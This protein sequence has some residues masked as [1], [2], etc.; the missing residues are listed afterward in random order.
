[1]FNRITFLITCI[2]IRL[3]APAQVMVIGHCSLNNVPI[4][5]VGIQV[6]ESGKVQSL[7]STA[8]SSLFRTRLNFGKNYIL[9]FTHPDCITQF[10]EVNA[11]SV[12]A[13]KQEMLM[14]YEVDLPFF[15]KADA[16]IDSTVFK[17]A[18]H[19][20]VWNGN[21]QMVDDSVYNTAFLKSV[22]KKEE[23]TVK[24]EN[25]TVKETPVQISGYFAYNGSGKL[26]PAYKEVRLLDKDNRVFRQVRTNRYGQF[27]FPPVG[28]ND[29]AWIELVFPPTEKNPN[30]AITLYSNEKKALDTK[31]LD[32]P[33]LRF[34]VT[35]GVFDNSFTQMI[36][37]KLIVSDPNQK[38]FFANTTVYL[39]NNRNT[40]LKK[41]KTNSFGAFVFENIKPGNDYL[42]GVDEDQL[43]SGQ[44]LDLINK[45]D[46][47]GKTLDSL[48]GKR[49]SAKFSAND[50][51][52][53]NDIT[54]SEEDMKM[55]ISATLYGDN[56]NNPLGKLKI[57]LLND[58]YEPI[59]SA[60]TDNFGTFKFKYLPFL[61]RFFLSA[62]NGEHNLDVFTNVLVYSS[63]ENLI[64][65]ITVIKGN[66]LVYKPLATEM[67]ALKD[68]Y[69]DDPWLD[70]LNNKKVTTPIIENIQFEFGK[71]DLLPAARQTLDKVVMVLKAN[72][73]IKIELLAH[74]DCKGKDTDNL[75]LS[76]A[77]AGSAKAYL[78][79]QGI[80]ED[81]IRSKG[82][83]ETRLLNLCSD[84]VNCNEE[85]H[86][87]NR[88]IEF[89]IIQN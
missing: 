49:Y 78:V 39:S 23:P 9:V 41:T 59:D 7:L 18:C 45:D 8:S 36:G 15:A 46:K 31:N 52:L 85:Q 60:V 67:S 54:L 3:L 22:L 79:K 87:Q 20:V 83:G 58:R 30:Q 42:I 11:S 48:I 88:R 65:V 72:Q 16:S 19:R 24:A 80:G 63:E 51:P 38:Q 61:K 62:D 28:M 64:K 29:A 10:M 55:N 5:N 70:V 71:H 40:I 14:T 68:V 25:T 56:I 21:R 82:L 84:G 13:E 47:F 17:N 73:N 53:Y 74:T 43:K 32:V 69:L 57:I 66:K 76:E 50:N 77:R 81:R 1:M 26:F 35:S 44:R 12:P 6:I 27:V 37:G 34:R 33:T 4:K 2:C 86:A 89:N 75:R